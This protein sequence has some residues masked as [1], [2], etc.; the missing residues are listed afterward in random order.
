LHHHPTACE[1]AVAVWVVNYAHWLNEFFTSSLH[2]AVNTGAQVAVSGA[3][4]V[5]AKSGWLGGVLKNAKTS[6]IVQVAYT[7]MAQAKILYKI[8]KG[9]LSFTEGMSEIKKVALSSMGSM[10]GAGYGAGIGAAIG[11]V[12]GPVGTAVGGFIGG[13]IGGIAGSAIGEAVHTASKFVADKVS[14]AV[15]SVASSVAS[16]LASAGRAI[17]SLFS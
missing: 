13:T 17:A 5:A 1:Y 11:T 4:V 2:G 8:A 7:G 3:V 9:E 16:G 14:S 10:A 12:L 6:T 15:K